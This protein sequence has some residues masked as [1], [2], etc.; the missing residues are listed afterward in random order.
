M[1]YLKY[2]TFVLIIVLSLTMLTSCGGGD[3]PQPAA[4]QETQAPVKEQTAQMEEQAAE[5][6]Q[7]EAQTEEQ[8]A[9]SEAPAETEEQTEVKETAGGF[10][11]DDVPLY[12]GAEKDDEALDM[13]GASDEGVRT[14]IRH[15]ITTDS[16]EKVRSYYQSEMPDYGWEQHTWIGLEPTTAGW[17]MERGLYEKQSTN[18]NASIELTEKGDGIVHMA[19]LRVGDDT[20]AASGSSPVPGLA[21]EKIDWDDIPIFPDSSTEEAGWVSTSVG[22]DSQSETRLYTTDKS[23]DEV[24]AFYQEEMIA[25]GWNEIMFATHGKITNGMYEKN[26]GVDAVQVTIVEEDD[27]TIAIGITRLRGTD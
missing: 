24:A 27:G 22:G 17:T 15:Y 21:G 20:G 11:W 14:E 1:K 13:G 4:E 19:L 10:T 6:G 2:L 23:M 3:E 7:E 18:D 9:E 12:P 25:N 5:S 26:D 16:F 8:E